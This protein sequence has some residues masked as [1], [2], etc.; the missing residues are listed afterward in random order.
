MVIQRG[1]LRNVIKKKMEP[2]DNQG[3]LLKGRIKKIFCQEALLLLPKAEPKV[4]LKVVT[5]TLRDGAKV[6]H[7]VTPTANYLET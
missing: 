7:K 1:Y 6:E 2:T 5:E 4:K 3:L